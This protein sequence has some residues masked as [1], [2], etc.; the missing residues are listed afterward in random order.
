MDILVLPQS[1]AVSRRVRAFLLRTQ[2]THDS[3]LATE[4]PA[5]ISGRLGSFTQGRL[6]EDEIYLSGWTTDNVLRC[7]GSAMGEI[8][9][10]RTFHDTVPADGSPD[11]TSIRQSK[12]TA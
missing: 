9:R 12:R 2:G 4:N 7:K 6:A 5:L 11:C 10:G 1:T 3:G 8:H